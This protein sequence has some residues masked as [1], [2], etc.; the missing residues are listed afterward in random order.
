MF[1]EYFILLFLPIAS[2]NIVFL[3][4]FSHQNHL[5][6]FFSLKMEYGTIFMECSRVIKLEW[7]IYGF[8]G[9]VILQKI[10]LMKQQ[11]N[12]NKWRE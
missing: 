4:S 5:T 8:L 3:P 9:M 1:E 2:I 10:Q 12:V 11:L 6:I 7:L